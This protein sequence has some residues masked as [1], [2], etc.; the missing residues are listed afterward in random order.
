MMKLIPVLLVFFISCGPSKSELEAQSHVKRD[1]IR[2]ASLVQDSAY[3][4]ELVL[5]FRHQNDSLKH[6]NDTLNTKLF[7]S[8][9]KVEKVKRYLEIVRRNR[10]QNKYLRGWVTR[11]VQ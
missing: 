6:L 10:S 1:S 2:L 4:S 8:E 9:F 3:C 11:A 5:Q 7:L